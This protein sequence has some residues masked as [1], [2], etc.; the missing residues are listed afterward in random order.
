MTSYERRK[1]WYD[2]L[3]MDMPLIDKRISDGIE[4]NRKGNIQIKLTDKSGRPVAGKRVKILQKS[5]DFKFGANLFM[6]KGF[7]TEREN[8]EYEKA[9]KELFNLATVPFYWNTLEP[10]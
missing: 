1:I 2:M 3:D 4:K 6:L 7:E 8:A 9:F 10:E 5:H